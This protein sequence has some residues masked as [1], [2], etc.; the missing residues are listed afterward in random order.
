MS[1]DIPERF[2]WEPFSRVEPTLFF[3]YTDNN[4]PISGGPQKTQTKNPWLYH[5]GAVG[6]GGYPDDSYDDHRNFPDATLY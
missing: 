5:D 2:F 3:R 6:G 1:R 4:V